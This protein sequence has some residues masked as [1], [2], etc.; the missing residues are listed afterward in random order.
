MDFSYTPE[1]EHFRR[2][3]RSWLEANVPADLRRGKDE[4]L[5]VDER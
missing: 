5:S 1:E 4:D 2:E 3:V